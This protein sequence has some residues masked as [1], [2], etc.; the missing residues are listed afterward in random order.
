MTRIPADLCD[1]N[2]L[3]AAVPNTDAWGDVDCKEEVAQ[4]I[5]E[6]D[7]LI[8]RPPVV[9]RKPGRRADRRVAEMARMQAMEAKMNAMAA[10]ISRLRHEVR[11]FKA[12]SRLS[13]EQILQQYGITPAIEH[14]V[15]RLTNENFENCPFVISAGPQSFG[16]EPNVLIAVHVGSEADPNDTVAQQVKWSRDVTGLLGEKSQAIRLNVQFA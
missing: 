10:E 8:Q 5:H 3:L 16:E 13:V 2:R 9:P 11:A 4:R 6:L 7:R 12:P 14:E 15:Y 1:R